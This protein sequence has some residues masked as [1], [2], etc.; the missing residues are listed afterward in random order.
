LG[1]VGVALIALLL[2]RSLRVIDL[3][4]PSDHLLDFSVRMLINLMPHYFGIALPAAFF[5]GILLTFNQLK[6]SNELDVLN[7]AG[8]G[9]HQ[10]AKPVFGM[11]IIISAAAFVLFGYLQPHG[12]YQYRFFVHQ[13]AQSSLAAAL[14]V[15]TFIHSDTST[16]YVEDASRGIE[17]LGKIFVLEEAENGSQ[18]ITMAAKG[19][20]RVTEDEQE[21]VLTARDGQRVEVGSDGGPSSLLSFKEIFW[22]V[23][24]IEKTQFRR[25][26]ADEREL[27]I[28]EIW[29]ARASPPDSID[30]AGLS[31]EF[32]GR[33]ANVIN[34]LILPLMAIPLALGGGRGGQV[35]GVAIGLI[36]LVVY[37]QLLQFGEAVAS[38]GAVSPWYG[39]WGL[40]A[41]FLVI[42]LAL[43]LRVAFRV[44]GDPYAL[45]NDATGR[46]LALLPNRGVAEKSA[47]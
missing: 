13:A 17:N 8:I 25:R 32:H 19:F 27:T 40:V 2:E 16:F 23:A 45:L 7:A 14:E 38:S 28:M 31:A 30:P 3:I 22:S 44:A 41:G 6:R 12:R 1:I 4:G 29:N 21:L 39:I 18:N 24:S 35:Y 36:I 46:L 5:G 26:G 42:S 37:Q 15:G 20:L 11:A 10:L 34:I 9:L 43:F 33:L 47:P